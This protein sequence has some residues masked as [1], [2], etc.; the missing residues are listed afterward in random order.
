MPT[1]TVPVPR[2]VLTLKEALTLEMEGWPKLAG[3]QTQQLA[4]Q[5][6]TQQVYE[7]AMF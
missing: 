1:L 7:A 4:G 5:K 2:L 6:V 3:Q